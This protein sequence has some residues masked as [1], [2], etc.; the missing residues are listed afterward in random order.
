MMPQLEDL[1]LLVLL[2]G[3]LPEWLRQ[4]AAI[5]AQVLPSSLRLVAAARPSFLLRRA[6]PVEVPL[7]RPL[8]QRLGLLPVLAQ[9]QALVLR[10]AWV[11]RR[12]LAACPLRTISSLALPFLLR[13][14]LPQRAFGFALPRTQLACRLRGWAWLTIIVPSWA[15][16]FAF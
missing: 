1:L 15:F 14:R 16:S 2:M 3:L 4:V 12:G 7:T 13:L 10:R 11:Q 6:V 5:Q 8:V 9:Q